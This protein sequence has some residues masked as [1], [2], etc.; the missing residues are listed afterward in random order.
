[1]RRKRQPTARELRRV[2]EHIGSLGLSVYGPNVHI[3][4]GLRYCGCRD[5]DAADI[6]A[7]RAFFNRGRE[8]Q[9]GEDGV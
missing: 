5:F 6:L 3:P 4:S 9:S 7:L 2:I 1:M 8:F